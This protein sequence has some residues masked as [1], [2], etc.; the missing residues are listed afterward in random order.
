MSAQMTNT[1]KLR[2]LLKT[3]KVRL[4]FWDCET[5]PMLVWTHYI[6]RKVSINHQQI[7]TDSKIICIQYMFEDDDKVSCLKFDLE[8]QDD[9]W[10]LQE[11]TKILNTENTWCITQNGDKFDIPTLQWRMN[12]LKLQTFNEIT[13]LDTLKLSK[14]VFRAPSHKLDYRSAKYG[15]G[16]KH[17]MEFQDWIDI[18]HKKK[19]AFNK[20]IVYGCKDVSDLRNIFWRELD[21]YTLP[22]TIE[23][24][25]GLGSTFCPECAERRQSKFNIT[26]KAFKGKP[27]YICNN[28][29]HR[30][31]DYV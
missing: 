25:L 4:L 21:S 12:L 6:G 23:K 15:F 27:G 11:F 30:W 13:S 26:N 10:I 16:G 1:E 22:A 28:C 9:T 7:E 17:H 5:S 31:S 3:Q 8:N 19:D 2:K 14:K 29:Q 24:A 20:M 18:C